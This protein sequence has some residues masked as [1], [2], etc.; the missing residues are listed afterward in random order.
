MVA[1]PGEVRGPVAGSGGAGGAAGLA[2][3]GDGT[4]EPRPTVIGVFLFFSKKHYQLL[5]LAL[6]KG[7][8]SVRYKTLGKDSFPESRCA[9]C[10]LPS[11]L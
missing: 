11:V 10:T 2:A 8:P 3:G 1:A 6:D 9:E 7:S 4:G 5:D